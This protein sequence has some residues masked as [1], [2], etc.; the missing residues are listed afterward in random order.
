MRMIINTFVAVLL[1]AGACGCSM[2][3]DPK[4]TVTVVVTGIPSKTES[5]QI[6]KTLK[7]MVSGPV[8]YTSSSWTGDTLTMQLSPVSNVQGFSSKIKFGN[9]TETQGNTVRVAFVKQ[10]GV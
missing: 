8:R 1:L 9:V 2:E 3:N 6:E 10:Q 5:E 4:L 7:S